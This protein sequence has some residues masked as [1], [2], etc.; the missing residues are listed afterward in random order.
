MSWRAIEALLRASHRDDNLAGVMCRQ[1]ISVDWQGYLHDCDF[2]QQLGL[3]GRRRSG[4]QRRC[5]KA[6]QRAP[7]ARP[8]G[9]RSRR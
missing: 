1:L 2:N 4:L 5:R 3:G 9:A 6:E 8:A 7:S